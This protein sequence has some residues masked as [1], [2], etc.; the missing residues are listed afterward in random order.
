M[1]TPNL[2]TAH[3]AVPQIYCY[4]MPGIPDH[5]GW[6]KISYTEQQSVVDR[7]KQRC[8]KSRIDEY[9]RSMESDA[10]MYDHDGQGDVVKETLAILQ[11]H[12]EST[13]ASIALKLKLSSRQVQRIMSKLRGEG[14]L[15]RHG[16]RK[17]GYWEVKDA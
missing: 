4:T 14:K 8:H 3:V 10:T 1:R 16:G 15:V 2:Q 17:D 13:A 6:V 11:A 7:V 5:D 9:K 12:P